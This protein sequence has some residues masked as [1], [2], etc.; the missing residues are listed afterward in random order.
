[1]IT[2]TD[3]GVGMDQETKNKAFSLFFSSKG[4]EGTGL[5]LF[6]SNKIALSHN[7]TISIE[8]TLGQGTCFT[9]VLPNKFKGE[10]S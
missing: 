2:I 7:G 3:N 4:T 9:I 5:G 10:V 1:M 8:S 6:V